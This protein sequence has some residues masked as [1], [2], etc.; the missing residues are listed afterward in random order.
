MPKERPRKK[1]AKQ[2]PKKGKKAEPQKEA[3]TTWQYVTQQPCCGCCKCSCH[4]HCGLQHYP[5][6]PQYPPQYPNSP[7]TFYVTNHT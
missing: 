5:S 1:A 2:Q 6:Y 4:S 7:G 3:T